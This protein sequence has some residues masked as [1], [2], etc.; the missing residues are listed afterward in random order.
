[1]NRNLLICGLTSAIIG[2]IC[3][4]SSTADAEKACRSVLGGCFY[5]HGPCEE[6]GVCGGL[7]SNRTCVK[8]N[9]GCTGGCP[10]S[11]DSGAYNFYCANTNAHACNSWWEE[12]CSPIK[13]KPCDIRSYPQCYCDNPNLPEITIGYCKLR[14]CGSS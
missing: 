5:E 3:L 4:Q 2:I 11:C 8:K 1:M 13:T 10:W 6:N 14:M 9:T 12:C 7:H